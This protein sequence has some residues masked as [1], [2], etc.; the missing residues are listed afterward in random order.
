M[1]PPKPKPPK[2]KNLTIR[3]TAL[4]HEKVGWDGV[5]CVLYN[6]NCSIQLPAA[7]NDLPG[8]P[9]F[10]GHFNVIMPALP[11]RSSPEALP[12]ALKL[13]R[14]GGL[15]RVP[16]HTYMYL[17]MEHHSIRYSIDCLPPGQMITYFPDQITRIC[18]S[19]PSRSRF[20]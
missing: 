6:I 13:G 1:S 7:T 9:A 14:Y 16:A 15:G 4:K 18:F 5:G 2:P 11:Y 3:L 20:N 10:Y 19:R 8:S 12:T 17:S